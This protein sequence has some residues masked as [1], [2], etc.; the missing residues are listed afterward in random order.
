MKLSLPQKGNLLELC[1]WQYSLLSLS[2][3]LCVQMCGFE[4]SVQEG[5]FFLSLIT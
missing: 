4:L 1:A 3:Q 5:P 2:D